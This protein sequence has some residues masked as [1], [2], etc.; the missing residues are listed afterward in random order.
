MGDRRF[1]DSSRIRA[2]RPPFRAL[3]GSGNSESPWPTPLRTVNM[4]LPISPFW[5]RVAAFAPVDSI[6]N[7]KPYIDA[8]P[9]RPWPRRPFFATSGVL[10]SWDLLWPVRFANR[11]NELPGALF[12]T[13]RQL[14][15]IRPHVFLTR[16]YYLPRRERRPPWHIATMGAV[17]PNVSKRGALRRLAQDGFRGSLQRRLTPCASPT[18]P[19]RHWWA[20]GVLVSSIYSYIRS[21][22]A[23]RF[24]P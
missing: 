19:S 11:K 10:I 6:R 14:F 1:G 15:A 18:S 23:W 9:A 12:P 24:R 5:G 2:L 7:P 8:P 22:C 17:R 3:C 13:G 20:R 21:I 4:R 16:M